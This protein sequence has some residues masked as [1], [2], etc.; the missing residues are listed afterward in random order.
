[1]EPAIGK[2]VVCPRRGPAACARPC[3]PSP[4]ALGLGGARPR[5]PTS[6]GNEAAG[7]GS[8]GPGPE[9]PRTRPAP[10]GLGA[11]AELL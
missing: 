4:R 2:G 1:L 8:R 11:P 5:R 9:V 6:P 3:A 10:P 7:A